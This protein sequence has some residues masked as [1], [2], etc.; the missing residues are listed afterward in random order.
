MNKRSSSS[1]SS[2][3]HTPKLDRNP[4][5]AHE[6]SQRCKR[7]SSQGKGPDSTLPA[8]RAGLRL[9]SRPAISY[10][11]KEMR[12]RYRRPVR[13]PAVFL[14]TVTILNGNDETPNTRSV[15]DQP[16][17]K[18]GTNEGKL[19]PHG[20]PTTGASCS[21]AS[22][23]APAAVTVSSP[24]RPRQAKAPSKQLDDGHRDLVLRATLMDRSDGQILAVGDA[25]FAMPKSKQA[26]RPATSHRP[27]L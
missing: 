21:L 20:S 26:S 11:T 10:V 18:N 19:H 4:P 23:T 2:V 15:K 14:I 3:I 16:D 12:V 9:S 6:P 1:S 25:V 8:S 17:G 13:T 7:Q 24:A 5:T 22:T 27:R